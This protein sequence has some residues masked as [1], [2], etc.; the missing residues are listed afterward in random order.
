MNMSSRMYISAVSEYL[1]MCTLI[2]YTFHSAA[3]YKDPPLVIHA[4]AQELSPQKV[5]ARLASWASKFIRY[6]LG[7]QVVSLGR[8]WSRKV[9]FHISINNHWIFTKFE[10][11]IYYVMIY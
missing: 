11:V 10:S 1:Y 3:F 2:C 4:L 9:K 5:K 6:V 7:K 8:A